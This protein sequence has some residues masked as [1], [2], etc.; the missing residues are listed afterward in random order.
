MYDEDLRVLHHSTERTEVLLT[1]VKADTYSD[2]QFRH[3]PHL[4]GADTVKD[5]KRH[6][7]HLGCMAVSVPGGDSRGHHVGISN[8]LYLHTIIIGTQFTENVLFFLLILNDNSQSIVNEK[9][10]NQKR[11]RARKIRHKVYVLCKML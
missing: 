4:K 6:V 7:G 5:V 10:E 8:S 1:R 2:F 11:H 9:K 3:V